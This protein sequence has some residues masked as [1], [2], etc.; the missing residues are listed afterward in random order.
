M[1]HILQSLQMPFKSVFTGLNGGI[2]ECAMRRRFTAAE[3]IAKFFY[4]LVDI[5]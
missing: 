5:T 4:F 2:L 1:V 3:K